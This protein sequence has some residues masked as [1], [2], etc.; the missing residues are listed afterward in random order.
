MFRA[1]IYPIVVKFYMDNV[2]ASV[3]NCMSA[4]TASISCV[5]GASAVYR[6]HQL[7]K[8]TIICI[9]KGQLCTTSISSVHRASSVYREHQPCKTR[10]SYV[11]QTSPL[12]GKNQLFTASISCVQQA[13]A[14]YSE[15]QGRD[16]L[17]S[18]NSS[19]FSPH[20]TDVQ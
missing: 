13:Y 8:G 15:H 11:Q 7:C 12:Y 6:E 4:C 3:I 14:V 17:K 20:C 10:I 5:H 16:F 9:T 18:L 1:L 2:C 19:A